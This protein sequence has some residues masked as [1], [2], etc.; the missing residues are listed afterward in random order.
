MKIIRLGILGAGNIARKM[1]LTAKLLERQ[2]RGVVLEAVAS[3]EYGKAEAFCR[4]FGGRPYGSYEEMLRSDVDLVYVATPHSH[5]YEHSKACLEAGK[6]VI[7]EKP[8]TPNARQCAALMALAKE[9]NLLLCEAIWTRYLPSRRMIDDILSSGILGEVR[10]LS[11]EFCQNIRNVPRIAQPELAGGGLLDLGVY[12][13]N[14]AEM[15]FGR[16]D[17]ILASCVKTPLGVDETMHI[18]MYWDDGRSASIVSCIS[19]VSDSACRVQGSKACLYVDNVNNPMHLEV[20]T[21][22][23]E[24]LLTQDCPEQL[25][26]FED[27]LLEACQCIRE[28]KTQCPSMPIQESLHIME[29]MDHVRAQCGIVY[30]FDREDVL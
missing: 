20:R 26:G 23:G 15:C 2:N 25:T 29:V 10:L 17:R 13:I 11:A 22:S 19:A 14:F 28:G 7:C 6:A 8:L 4:E 5:H 21:R 24:C 27:E 12:P 3:R 9:K 1:A 18:Q 30:P 16:A